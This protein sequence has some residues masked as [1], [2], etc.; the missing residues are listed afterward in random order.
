MAE[1]LELKKATTKKTSTKSIDLKPTEEKVEGKIVVKAFNDYDE[2]G[3]P[4][5]EVK[6]AVTKKVEVKKEEVKKE[7]PKKDNSAEIEKVTKILKQSNDSVW[8]EF[9][10][11][12]LNRLK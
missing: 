11:K 7:E 12:E 1:E 2:D 10:T 8:V 4:V 3:S 6:P 9:W 5:K